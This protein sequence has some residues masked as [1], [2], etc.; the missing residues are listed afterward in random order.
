M[1]F[2]EPIKEIGD[3]KAIKAILRQHSQRDVLFFVLGIN[4]GIT[5]RDLLSLKVK[6]VW[7]GNEPRKFLNITESHTFREKAFYLNRSAARELTTYLSNSNADQNDCLF[8]SKKN[9]NPIT[10]QQAYRIVNQAAKDAGLTGKI[11]TH[12]LR[13]TFAYHAY[14]K[15]IA[16]SII[17]KI[18]NHHS[19]SETLRYIGIDKHEN[20]T[21][22]VDVNL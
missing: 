16:I 5:I 17:A 7:D 14:Q 18:L 1:E 13:K 8:K 20:N 10:R 19:S 6:D 11:G 15:G 2:V 22:K 4:T 21:V 3:I 12:T 9:N